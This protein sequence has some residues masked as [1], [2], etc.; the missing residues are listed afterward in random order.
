MAGFETHI[1]VSTA[2]GIGYGAVGYYLG[3]P[4]ESCALAAGLCSL[5]GMIPD[6][7]SDSGTPVRETMTL[8][9]AVVPMLTMERFRQFG[10]S[11]ETT[12]LVAAAMYLAVRFGVA[13]LFKRFTVH[14][15]MWHSIP[16]CLIAGLIAF[17]LVS[18]VNLDI[19]LYKA[20]GV[21]LGFLSHLVLDEI[22]SFSLKG[23]RFQIK[24]SFGTALKF[25]GKSRWANVATYA[26][27]AVVSFLAVGDPVM[28]QQMGYEMR[29]GDQ[30]AQAWFDQQMRAGAVQPMPPP[31]ALQPTQFP[32]P[33]DWRR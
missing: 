10:W 21:L 27:L 2:L 22:W 13:E 17:M 28:M 8:T 6:L 4:P 30:S 18:G 16:A 25:W 9:A 5:S 15:G 33:D 26:K 14:R 24:K 23:G 11:H 1:G 29:V 20:G 32:P 31:Q 12:V 19:R 3:L 7:D